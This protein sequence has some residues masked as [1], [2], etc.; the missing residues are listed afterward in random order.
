MRIAVVGV[1]HR[2]AP[3]EVREQVA[4]S[5]ERAIA[6]AR[7]LREVGILDEVVVLSTCNR[8]ELYG[9]PSR[10]RADSFAALEGF[11]H[12]FHRISPSTLNGCFYRYGDGEAV[13][14]LF[15]VASGLDSMLLGEAEILGQV[16]ESYRNA[17]EAHS[18]GPVL[19]R[20]FQA[21]L[22]VGKRV[23]SE[24]ELG[25]GPMS[26]A[27]AAVKLAE[28]VFGRLSE[29]SALI[30]G[31]GAMGE[32]LVEHLRLRSIA[33]LL[34]ANR[35]SERAAALAGRF[36]GEAIRW[37]DL[38]GVIS[39]PDIIIS[40]VSDSPNL[41][42]GDL[43]A[44]AMQQ[45][46]TR[47]VFLIDLAVPRNIEAAAGGLYNV[48]LYNL[49]DLTGIVEQNRRARQREIPRA[50]EIVARHLAKFEDWQA[51]VEVVALL[52]ELRAKL[53]NE[54]AE[55]LS[56]RLGRMQHLSP[57]ERRRLES[58]TEELVDL[59]L[60]A[61]NIRLR[62]PAELRRRLANIETVREVFGLSEEPS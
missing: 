39:V 35:S 44:R 24:T 42:R 33:R 40:S 57:E 53:Q 19:N 29:S 21:A 61:P 47:P 6:A 43:I 2:T 37:T 12:S 8:S 41:L 28:Q 25:A 52:D 26:V 1:N 38:E 59:A 4:F 56:E 36:R 34:V 18:T 20:L 11:F 55:F 62:N 54:R 51:G 9:V 27:L 7:T 15:R 23:R 3:L 22:E 45:R 46:H 49:D 30:L 48:Y 5:G 32:Q 31:A 16:R 60:R 17:V 58:V 13:Q 14:H 50:E 10:G